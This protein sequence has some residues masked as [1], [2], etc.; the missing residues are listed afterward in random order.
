MD[1]E[2]TC[3][4]NSP[5]YGYIG[6]R[7]EA[8]GKN[9]TKNSHSWH[10]CFSFAF[11]LKKKKLLIKKFTKLMLTIACNILSMENIKFIHFFRNWRNIFVKFV[12]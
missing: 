11:N 4:S 9:Y 7:Y 10:K 2:Y 12:F 1:N 5:I 8:A 6:Y 3:G